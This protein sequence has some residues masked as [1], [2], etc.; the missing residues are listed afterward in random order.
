MSSL[1]ALIGALRFKSMLKFAWL[2]VFWW[3]GGVTTLTMIA[4]T[5]TTFGG[6]NVEWQSYSAFS[7]A[8]VALCASI[9]VGMVGTLPK[10]WRL[11]KLLATT[12]GTVGL[13]LS[14]FLLLINVVIVNIDPSAS[15]K[16]I[17]GGFY[18]IFVLS[19]LGVITITMS[20]A[21]YRYKKI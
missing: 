13:I 2:S 6:G 12:I 19:T 7:S 16:D 5:Y 18:A 10:N 17:I 20:I 21:F 1:V 15:L 8:M 3:L 4:A 14:A 9:L 11:E